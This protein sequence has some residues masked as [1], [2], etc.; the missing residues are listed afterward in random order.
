MRTKT[1]HTKIWIAC[2]VAG[3][4]AAAAADMTRTYLVPAYAPCPGP[5]TCPATLS[6]TFSFSSAVLKNAKARY[7]A[8]GK[9]TLVVE[10]KGV[11]DA[12]GQLVTTDPGNAADDFLLVI[13]PA[14]VTIAGIGTLPPGL[15]P[16][17][18]LHID[19]KN[20]DGSQKLTTPEETPKHGLVANSAGLPMV[21]DSQGKVLA[22]TGSQS[23]P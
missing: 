23:P 14:Q 18:R 11:K 5:A 9:V 19:L 10:L 4:P 15:S 7:L 2:L 8:P 16:E 13:S 12:S 21:F 3:L 22:V 17:T 6:S 20:G 1:V